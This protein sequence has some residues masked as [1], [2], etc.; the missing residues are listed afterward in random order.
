MFVHLRTRGV[1]FGRAVPFAFLLT[2]GD[3]RPPA[4]QRA[5]PVA[6]VQ[7]LPRGGENAWVRNRRGKE[8]AVGTRRSVSERF[9][10]FESGE[11]AQQ[12]SRPPPPYRTGGAGTPGGSPAASA[13]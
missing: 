10:T 9:C 13:A 12:V 6:D 8:T 3:R 1:G 11:N 4:R 2:V 5:G 7:Q